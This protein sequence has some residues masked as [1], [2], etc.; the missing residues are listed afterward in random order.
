[1]ARLF[2]SPLVVA[3]LVLAR[4]VLGRVLATCLL[5]VFSL[6]ML[7]ACRSSP[8]GPYEPTTDVARDVQRSLELAQQA[9]ALVESHPKKAE[10]LLREALGLDLY[11]GPAH[12][13]LGVIHLARDDL[14]EA[15]SQFEWARKLMPGHPDPRLN[16][17]LTLERAGRRE[18]AIAMYDTALEVMPGHLPSVK[19]L[20]R[21]QLQTARTDARTPALLSEVALRG[22]TE[23]W[24][25]WAR[26]HLERIR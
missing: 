12:N 17:A 5:V 9:A 13:N 3:S 1:M 19:G 2:S 14:Y 24:R 4:L 18:E 22:E 21:L 23:Q 15:A 10:T 20:V 7:A 26:L 11:N 6:S 16:L 25:N 8:S